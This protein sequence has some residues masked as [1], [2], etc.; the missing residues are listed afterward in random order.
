MIQIAAVLE[1]L[2]L[3]VVATVLAYQKPNAVNAKVWVFD[4]GVID[5][6]LTRGVARTCQD[7]FLAESTVA[8]VRMTLMEG[9]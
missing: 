6:R 3:V 7:F 9:C 4:R 8:W 5:Q 2:G 1:A